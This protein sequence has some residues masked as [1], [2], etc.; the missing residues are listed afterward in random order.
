MKKQARVIGAGLAGC[1]ASWQLAQH[2]WDVE[3]YEMK[4]HVFSPAH[5]SE[6]LAELVCSNSF[7]SAEVETGIGLLKLEMAELGSL[8]MDVARQTMLPAGKALAVD[9]ERFAS[10]ITHRIVEHP[11]ITLVRR[12]IQTLGELVNVSGPTVIAAG[13]LMSSALAADLAQTIGQRVF[14]VLRCD[15]S[16]RDHGL[17]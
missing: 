2:G 3:L 1:E 7:R 5:R 17:N 13:P 16:Y 14:G 10:E 11:R 12:E 4:P 15:R 8:V 9:R 6:N